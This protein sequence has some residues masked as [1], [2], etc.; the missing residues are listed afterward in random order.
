MARQPAWF[1]LDSTA[2]GD[3]SPVRQSERRA[4]TRAGLTEKILDIKR[5][6]DWSWR[7]ICTEIGGISDV[8]IVGALMGQMKLVKPMARKAAVLF[9]L[10][11]AEERML[12][13]EQLRGTPMPPTDQLI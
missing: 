13:E 6:K 8:L 11:I 12:N 9:G 5:E 2:T 3:R 1:L 7:H 4:L 10:S